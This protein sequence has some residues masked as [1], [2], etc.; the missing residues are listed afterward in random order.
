MAGVL[1]E[2]ASRSRLDR[3]WR[4][5]TWANAF[6]RVCPSEISPANKTCDQRHAQSSRIRSNIALTPH[7]SIY[8][9]PS[10]DHNDPS[11]PLELYQ[12]TDRLYAFR[13]RTRLRY[14]VHHSTQYASRQ[15][16]EHRAC[17]HVYAILCHATVRPGCRSGPE[18]SIPILEI[19]SLPELEDRRYTS[20]N[21][22]LGETWR[23]H[24]DLDMAR[25]V[26]WMVRR[27]FN[28]AWNV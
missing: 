18:G 25:M 15:A 20:K 27:G 19:Q 3:D 8:H 10:Q 1:P 22:V 12:V 9:T 11:S 2:M 7:T 16:A 28:E 6:W 5:Y 26:G 23:V 4:K 13:T 21:A 17:I 14:L 24:I